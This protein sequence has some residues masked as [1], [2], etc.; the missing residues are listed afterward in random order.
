MSKK[1]Q[2][3]WESVRTSRGR[4]TMVESVREQDIWITHPMIEMKLSEQENAET[5]VEKAKVKECICTEYRRDVSPSLH[6]P[7]AFS[8]R[9]V[10]DFFSITL[11]NNQVCER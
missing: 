4:L 11:Q 5:Q 7:F 3:D 9:F 1:R 10:T 2:I 6:F 8:V